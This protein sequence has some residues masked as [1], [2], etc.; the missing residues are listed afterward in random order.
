MTWNRKTS[1]D[2]KVE[3]KRFGV[4]GSGWA[5]SILARCY[6]GPPLFSSTFARVLLWRGGSILEL[7]EKKSSDVT[8]F[9][10]SSKLEPRIQTS[11]FE[12]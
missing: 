11:I 12:E 10:A 5:P 6:F 2:P 8:F 7:E 9:R 3:V 4:W 1:S